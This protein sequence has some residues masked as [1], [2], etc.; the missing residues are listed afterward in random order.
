MERGIIGIVG[1]MGPEAGIS[2][3]GMIMRHT[4]A[5]SD[6]DHL[7]VALFSIPGIIP[8]RTAYITGEITENPAGGILEVL[9]LMKR[10]GVTLAALACNSAH[11]PVIFDAVESGLKN[12]APEIR[13][14]NMIEE[15]GRF[16]SRQYPG[17]SRAGIL[18]TTGTWHTRLYDR[19]HSMG[20][21]TVYTSPEEQQ[22]LHQAIYHPGYGIKSN[23]GTIPERAMEIIEGAASSLKK[24]G[25]EILV[26]GC[27]EISLAVK[28]R[29]YCGL[30]VADSSVILARALISA[31]SPEKLRPGTQ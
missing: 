15:A 21:Q 30:P 2:L 27:T 11:A 25:A 8:D 14:I 9:S 12:M 19:L 3:S 5:R 22:S 17:I 16:I 23:S 10:A 28:E 18:S 31:H 13:L 6:Q 20:L 29:E 1:G 26:L 4:V 24:S 7:P